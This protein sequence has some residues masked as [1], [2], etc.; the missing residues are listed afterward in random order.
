MFPP[1]GI[2]FPSKKNV[3][4]QFVQLIYPYLI[5]LQVIIH[6]LNDQFLQFE[7]QKIL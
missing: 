4:F 7:K 2:S 3:M 5:T 1:L 6:L